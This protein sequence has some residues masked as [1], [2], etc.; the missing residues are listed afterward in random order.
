MSVI[1]LI[2]T[3]PKRRPKQSRPSSPAAYE[4]QLQIQDLTTEAPGNDVLQP[5]ASL[6]MM[7]ERLYACCGCSD[8]ER[9]VKPDFVGF[10]STFGCRGAWS[11]ER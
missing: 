4:A 1:L 9:N 6:S 5:L 10:R 11:G 8:G 3:R 2:E 7:R